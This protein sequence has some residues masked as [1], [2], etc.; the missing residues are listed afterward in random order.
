MRSSVS[1]NNGIF[2]YSN[3]VFVQ[4]VMA[5][6]VIY[7]MTR[8]G[9]LP[10]VLGVIASR[11][12]TPGRAIAAV[13]LAIAALA[14]SLPLIQLA[15]FTSLVTL[16]VFILVNLSLWRIGAT[17]GGAAK[18]SRWRCWG[19]FGGLVSVGLLLS[20]ILRIAQ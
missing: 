8:E 15:Q 11:R 10:A 2:F 18:L 17:P 7:G 4:I 3:G 12:Q 16:T 20:E 14:L 13:A 1:T 5:S 9:M 19:L 6:R